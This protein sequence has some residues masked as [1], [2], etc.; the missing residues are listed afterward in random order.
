[1][2]TH[3]NLYIVSAFIHLIFSW[4]T[5][6]KF[7]NNGSQAHKF[8][9]Q[10]EKTEKIVKRKKNYY[11]W[12]VIDDGDRKYQDSIWCD[13]QYIRQISEFAMV[14]TYKPWDDKTRI[15]SIII[16]IWKLNFSYLV[17]TLSLYFLLKVYWI[18]A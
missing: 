8:L 1:M 14:I 11:N 4:Y 13:S 18:V 3:L 9:I 5:N 2:G 15:G 7:R 6:C 12:K 17:V 16:I 10:I